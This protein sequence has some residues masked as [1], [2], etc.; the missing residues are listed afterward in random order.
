MIVLIAINISTL[1]N[2]IVVAFKLYVSTIYYNASPSMVI[3]LVTQILYFT[4]LESI[5]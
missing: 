3:R 2:L 1:T 4:L 5:T